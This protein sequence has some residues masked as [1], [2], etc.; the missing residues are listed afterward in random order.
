MPRSDF[1][2]C[3]FEREKKNLLEVSIPNTRVSIVTP[4]IRRE[5]LYTPESVITTGVNILVFAKVPGGDSTVVLSNPPLPSNIMTTFVSP[6]TSARQVAIKN[7]E[8]TVG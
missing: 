5:H 6:D 8:L 2:T 7:G 1:G 4:L 3:S